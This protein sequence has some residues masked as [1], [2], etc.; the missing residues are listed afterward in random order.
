MSQEL[1]AGGKPKFYLE[2]RETWYQIEQHYGFFVFRLGEIIRPTVK[3]FPEDYLV[4]GDNWYQEVRL[5]PPYWEEEDARYD[6]P[7]G[8]VLLITPISERLC[9]GEDNEEAILN[10]PV[11]DLLDTAEVRA[12]FESKDLR[13]L[14]MMAVFDFTSEGYGV[15]SDP[16]Q[17]EVCEEFAW[18]KVIT[19]QD[20][21][22]FIYHIAHPTFKI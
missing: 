3:D 10:N 19:Y 17:I 13:V 9:L 11:L 1:L 8:R 6:L 12:R 2:A 21:K 14:R 18:G 22:P 4:V 15:F 7:D 16:E 5:N 20:R